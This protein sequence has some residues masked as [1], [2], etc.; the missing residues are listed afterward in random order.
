MWSGVGCTEKPTGAFP[1][2][3]LDN[4]DSFTNTV[5]FFDS[6]LRRVP[7]PKHPMLGRRPVLS[8]N[9]LKRADYYEW[10]DWGTV[11]LRRRYLGSGLRKLFADGVAGGREMDVVGLYSGNCPGARFL[12]FLSQVFDLAGGVITCASDRGRLIAMC[13]S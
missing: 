8:K 1:L 13:L 2:L 7:S 11:D 5:E 10:I 9:P 3:T 6:G 4:P 12:P